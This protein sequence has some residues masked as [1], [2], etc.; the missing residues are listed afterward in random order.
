MTNILDKERQYDK[1]QLDRKDKFKSSLITNRADDLTHIVSTSII[2]SPYTLI[3][4]TD[5]EARPIISGGN[6]IAAY[7][8]GLVFEE[9]RADSWKEGSGDSAK[10]VT[11]ELFTYVIAGYKN[12]DWKIKPFNTTQVDSGSTLKG[13][14]RVAYHP[15]IK[16]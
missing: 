16:T 7:N 12:R 14:L 10:H 6:L 11:G 3:P 1:E 5:S 8:D 4:L 13:T 9:V 2:G 15:L